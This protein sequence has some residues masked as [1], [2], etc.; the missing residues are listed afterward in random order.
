MT[1]PPPITRLGAQHAA[2]RELS[3]AIYHHQSGPLATRGINWIS[4][5]IDKL[6]SRSFGHAPG[7]SLGALAIV[8]VIAILIALVVWRVGPLQRSAA[9]RSVLDTGARVESASD[10]RRRAEQAAAVGDYTTAVIE[11]MRAV[12]RE[13]EE[14]HLLEARAGRTASELSREAGVVVPSAANDLRHAADIFNSVAY[15]GVSADRAMYAVLL[16]AD[17]EVRRTS[18]AVAVAR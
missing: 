11:G 12:A 4:K 15:G 18:R 17:E 5:Q 14:R 7:G 6:L 10:H 1:H 8:I 13:L 3:K 9:V 16:A 2:H